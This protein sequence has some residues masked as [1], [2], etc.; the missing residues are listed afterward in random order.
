MASMIK[1]LLTTEVRVWH[2]LAVGVL[3]LGSGSGV[4]GASVGP[5][6]PVT[7]N[8]EAYLASGSFRMA[9]SSATTPIYV[10]SNDTFPYVWTEVLRATFTIPSGQRAGII[11][12]FNA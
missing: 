3:I 4:M 7:A 12:F 1:R 8:P 9:A 6:N 11:A 2:L 10:K 5:E